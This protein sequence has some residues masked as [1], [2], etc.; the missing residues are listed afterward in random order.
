MSLDA[1][2]AL[3]FIGPLRRKTTTF[4]VGG[5]ETNL[6]LSRCM[7][8]AAARAGSCTI[9]DLDAF[10]S[11]YADEVMGELTPRERGAVRILVPMAGS[12]VE[13]PLSRLCASSSEVVIVDSLNTLYHTLS[14]ADGGPR[15]RKVGFAIEA[16][17]YASRTQGKAALLTMYSREGPSRS[18]SGRPISHLSDVTASATL[19][20]PTLKFRCERGEAWPG[21]EFSIRSP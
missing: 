4:L 13:R 17:S 3:S 12:E 16:L 18:G 21:G 14:S 19:E 7:A 20:G 6:V 2:Q 10:Y 5:R 8:S 1:K 11:S 15:G 9:L